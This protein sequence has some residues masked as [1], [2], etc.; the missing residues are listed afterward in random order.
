MRREITTKAYWR[1][2]AESGRRSLA[3]NLEK[4]SLYAVY[5]LVGRRITIK[6]GRKT[7]TGE[8][9]D[10]GRRVSMGEMEFC[11]SGKKPVSLPY[12]DSLTHSGCVISLLYGAQE[13]PEMSDKALF[14]AMSRKAYRGS[15]ADVLA[16]TETTYEMPRQAK[17]T[18]T[19]DP[20]W[21][22]D[23]KWWS[24]HLRY[25]LMKPPKHRTLRVSMR[26]YGRGWTNKTAP[27]ASGWQRINNGDTKRAR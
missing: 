25:D 16:W 6:S 11:L 19:I 1:V 12:P 5:G 17:V 26:M 14:K 7:W 23:N 3:A 24:K 22:P 21:T 18:I 10:V 2:M 15:L 8:L 9:Y 13:R 27:R 20:N 4:N